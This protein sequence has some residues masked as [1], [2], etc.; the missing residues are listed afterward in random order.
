MAL[1]SPAT[2]MFLMGEEVG[3]QKEYKYNTFMQ[4]RENLRAARQGDGQRLFRFYQDVIAFRRSHPG[5]RTHA[6]D[7]LHVHNA[8]RLLAFRRWD[9][10]EELLVVASLNNHPF[11][12]GYVIAN[13]RLGSGPWR[14]IFNSDAQVY[15]GNNVGNQGAA[16]S[17]HH[18][19][20]EVLIPANG[21]VVFLKD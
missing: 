1:L 3:A 10:S 15:G 13:P 12:A 18:G 17:V 19:L 9:D 8:N 7:I 2:P 5:L 4:N 20:L 21:F 11:S 14:E 6:V 16:L